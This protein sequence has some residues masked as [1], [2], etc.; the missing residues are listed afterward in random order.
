VTVAA[1]GGVVT[2]SGLGIT[3]PAGDYTITF[4]ATGLTVATQNITIG[5]AAAT[6]IVTVTNAVG[7]V[8]AVAFTSQPVLRFQ[9]ANSFNV[10]TGS[11]VTATL[12]AGSAGSSLIGTV[13]V[14]A[15]NGVVTFIGLGITGPAGSYTITFTATGLTVATQTITIG[16]ASITKV[17]TVTT[18]S[19]GISAIAFTTQPVIAFQDADSFTV[20]TGSSVTASITSGSAG[21][22]LIGTVTVA[23]INGVVT[24]SGLGITGPAGSY[25]ITFT[26]TGLT[27]ATQT[28]TIGAAAATKIVMTTNA[29]GAVSATA[30][31]TQPV[32]TFQDANNF[33]VSS[34]SSVTAT[35][36]AGS[37]GS[38]LLGT[39]TFNA[40]NGVVTFSGLGITG[41]SG[42]YTI[43]FTASG[44]T[45]A[46]QTITLGA[47]DATKI[48]N[49]TS[50][51]G[52]VSGIAFTTQPVV[53]FQDANS[54]AVSTN[55]SVTA[56]ITS[57]SAGASLLGTVTVAAVNGVVTF[58]GLGITGAGGS[59]TLT[60][61]ASGLTVATQTITLGAAAATKVV[62]TTNAAGAVSAVAFG[63]QPVL[64][65]QDANSFTISSGSSIT[66]SLTAGS[67]GVLNGTAT[68][69]AVNGVVTFS[70]LGITGPSGSYTITFTAAGLTV[71][72][73]TITLGAGAATKV[74][75]SINAAGAV[76][77]V[78][79]TTQPAVAF[80]DANSFAVSTGSSI[81]ASLTS[82]SGGSLIGTVTVNAIN[83]VVTFSGLGVTGPSGSYTITFTAAGLTVAT[84]TITLGAGAASKVSITR[85]SV[86]TANGIAFTTQPQISIQ[87]ASSNTVVSD[88]SSIVTATVSSGGT[89]T[90][91][92]TATAVAGVATFTTLTLQGEIGTTFTITYTVSGLTV[93]TSTVTLSAGVTRTVTYTA[94]STVVTGTAPTQADV[95]QGLSFTLAANTF[96]RPGFTFTTWLSSGS[97]IAALSYAVGS[98]FTVGASNVTMTAQWSVALDSTVTFTANNGVGA[99]YTQA[100]NAPTKLIPNT[101][102][103]A[104]FTFAGWAL[105]TDLDAA[106]SYPN[107]A[108]YSFASNVTLFA[109]WNPG[110]RRSITYALGGGAGTLPVQPPTSEGARFTVAE[111]SGLTRAGFT[112]SDWTDGT[113]SY[114]P[115]TTYLVGLNN[116]TLTAQWTEA[117][118]H[119]VN[120]VLAGG[121]GTVPTQADVVEGLNFIVA[122]RPANRP[123]FTFVSWSDGSSSFIPGSTYVVGRGDVTLTAVWSQNVTHTVTYSVGSTSVSVG[124]AALTPVQADV[125]EGASF[126]LAGHEGFTRPGFSFSKWSD[127]TASFDAGSAYT[128]GSNNVLLTAVWILN[129]TRTVTYNLAGGIGTLPTQTPVIQGLTF[130]TA[131]STGFTREGFTFSN[132][133]NGAVNYAAGATYTASTTNIVLTAVWSEVITRTI[134]YNLGGGTGTLPTQANVAAGTTFVVADN[135]G[136]T[137]AGFAFTGWSDGVTSF[138]AGATYTVGATNITLTATW[139]AIVLRTIT[140]ALG[141]GTGTLPKQDPTST[142]SEI[143][144]ASDAGISRNGFTFTSWSDGTTSFAP[145]A[146]YT[147]P[148]RNVVLTALWSAAPTRTIRYALGGGV[149]T[150]PTEDPLPSGGKFV[151]APA[152]GLTRV[153]FTFSSWSNGATNFEPGA[154]YTVGNSNIVLTAVW[155]AAAPRSITYAFGG[156]TGT[157]P[158]QGAVPTGSTFTVAVAATISR[159]GFAFSGWS[160]GTVTL[161]PGATYTVG[162]VNVVLT[163]QWRSAVTRSITYATGGAFGTKPA[164]LTV[165]VG[166]SFTVAA[167]TG[168]RK[169]RSSFGSW[170]D[171]SRNYAPGELYTVGNSNI[172]LTAIWIPALT[173]T[174]TYSLGGG[175]GPVPVQNPVAEGAT[176]RIPAPIGITRTGFIFNGWSN[177]RT[178]YTVG[179]QV[180]MGTTDIV[181]T[182]LW[183]RG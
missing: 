167:A 40:V 41:P 107:E 47:A 128:M 152:T 57:G 147:V 160:D 81:T 145:G 127:G 161:Q 10:S 70:N 45:V 116:I 79:F 155:I 27:V 159:T 177:G 3:G 119:S 102:T 35:L 77:G 56:S 7:A 133:N 101:F 171:G 65:I 105:S 179:A 58:S 88:S 144:I 93:A 142:G 117:G 134:T 157:L 118:T 136:I 158:I 163:A 25:T 61:A 114:E 4:T 162:T 74:V 165:A 21:A 44:L 17:A 166:A 95:A 174:V 42:A 2:F 75:N 122:E 29:S 64:A 85:A 6:K 148:S 37:A 170:S 94:G 149:G 51:S 151:V 60:F 135:D 100:A 55:S 112:F 121:T 106:I 178:L 32:L 156:G 36:T 82:G 132:W 173:R 176:F 141:G 83:G 140:Y 30:F 48:V 22:S 46:T 9:D 80:Q 97:G 8:S 109:L 28:I 34:G 180:K 96:T 63:T 175:V 113:L 78:A 99:D 59:Y 76:S 91:S 89:L 69:T 66:A 67:G 123:G 23:A 43:T 168:L 86:G 139:S 111:G 164:S 87:D 13:T 115:G 12:T 39:T 103:R 50:A 92:T 154:T 53:S 71:A 19:G 20:S 31:T 183:R 72:T 90:G 62:I 110:T 126:I 68:V 16:A 24:F 153:G 143:E 172:T 38:S 18:A 1:V 26:A 137:R 129:P 150:I 169:T 130:R 11:S 54:F 124:S 125:P 49:T 104:G 146:I 131:A 14:N 5:D 52:A 120:Y 33:T 181:I 108:T 138:S 182:A 15:V 98:S 73:Q 84:Q